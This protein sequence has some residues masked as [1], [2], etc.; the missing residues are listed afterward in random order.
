MIPQLD[1]GLRAAQRRSTTYSSI[2][3]ERFAA[4]RRPCEG[5]RGDD[6]DE[7]AFASEAASG[8]FEEVIVFMNR[9]TSRR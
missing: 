3:W 9:S 8:L 6:A 5:L 1:Y 7:S 4:S 2:Q